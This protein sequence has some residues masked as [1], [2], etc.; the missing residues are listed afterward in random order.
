[1]LFHLS[2]GQDDPRWW[3]LCLA[4]TRGCGGNHLLLQ[5]G[6]GGGREKGKTT[7]REKKKVG[8]KGARE[9]RNTTSAWA[10]LDELTSVQFR[11]CLLATWSPSPVPD[12]WKAFKATG[13]LSSTCHY[14]TAGCAEKSTGLNQGSWVRVPAVPCVGR[15]DSST[16]CGG[17][18]RE[19]ACGK[20]A[21]GAGARV[22]WWTVA[23]RL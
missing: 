21:C 3:M 17:D 14:L 12:T 15:T 8:R 2:L 9:R 6:K 16:V 4:E 18:S 22:E 11:K 5:R 10:M 20:R 13:P 1:M 23:L 7:R 19:A